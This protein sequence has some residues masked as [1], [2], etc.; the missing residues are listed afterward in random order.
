[1]QLGEAI[2]AIESLA[3]GIDPVTGQPLPEPGPYHH[4]HVI[5]ALFTVLE[6]ARRASEGHASTRQ[7]AGSLAGASGLCERVGKPWTPAEDEQL[8]AE[9]H[10]AVEFREMAK[11][12]GRTRG[13]IVSRLTKLGEIQPKYVDPAPDMEPDF[14]VPK[15]DRSQAGKP[16][17]SEHD[18]ELIRHYDAGLPLEEIAERL[19]RG[20]NAVEVRLIKLG[21]ME[22]DGD[23]SAGGTI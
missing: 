4:P 23:A 17:T 19:Q 2:S 16:W 5:R 12:H 10:A 3:N 13:A 7:T 9:F 8:I 14:E 21:K 20:V 15:K 18:A 11:L 1:M 22:C 6:Q